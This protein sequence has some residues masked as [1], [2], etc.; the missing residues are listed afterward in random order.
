[1]RLPLGGEFQKFFDRLALER[2]FNFVDA[3]HR[4]ADAAHLALVLA[5]DD[6]L[7]NPLDHM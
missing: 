7:E 1:M 3:S 6:F 4:R 5:S 2:F